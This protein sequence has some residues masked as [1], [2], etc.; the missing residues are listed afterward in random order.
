MMQR[1]FWTRDEFGMGEGFKLFRINEAFETS[2]LMS[3]EVIRKFCDI[4]SDT[5]AVHVDA[6]YARKHGF[7]EP[8]VYGN[9]LGALISNLVGMHLPSSEVIILRESIDFR[10]PVYRGD[11]VKLRATVASVHEAVSSVQMK[12]EFTTETGQVATGTCVIKCL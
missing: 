1:W 12:L 2:L 10:N 8:I 4:S 9:L 11:V 6:A 7:R 5:N 3:E